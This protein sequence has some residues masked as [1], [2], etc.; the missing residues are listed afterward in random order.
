MFTAKTFSTINKKRNNV[1]K[2]ILKRALVFITKGWKKYKQINYLMY[3]ID[4]KGLT[5][6]D[7]IFFK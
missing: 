3:P 7:V 1:R 4:S 2:F 6:K 5:T